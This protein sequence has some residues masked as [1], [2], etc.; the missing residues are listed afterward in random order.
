MMPATRTRGRYGARGSLELFGVADHG[1]S[2]PVTKNF[3][4]I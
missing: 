4:Y 2:A 1:K 3:R